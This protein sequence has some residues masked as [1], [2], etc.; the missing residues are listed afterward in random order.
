M[1]EMNPSLYE[2][3]LDQIQEARQ[4]IHSKHAESYFKAYRIAIEKNLGL[5]LDAYLSECCSRGTTVHSHLN[6]LTLMLAHNS[7]TCLLTKASQY[8]PLR[9]K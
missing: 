8:V 2:Q 6:L 4:P 7:Y 1:N 3:L 5:Q 9:N